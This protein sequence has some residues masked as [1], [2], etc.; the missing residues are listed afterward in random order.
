MTEMEGWGAIKRAGEYCGGEGRGQDKLDQTCLTA[1]AFR[2]FIC[3]MIN[4]FD[5][6]L[7]C[8]HTSSFV[9]STNPNCLAIPL[10]TKKE[11]HRC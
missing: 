2:Q 11:K 5:A 6:F 10:V 3:V 4:G 1:N 9:L 7:V 8:K